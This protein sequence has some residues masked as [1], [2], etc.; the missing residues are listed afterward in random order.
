MV[1]S[2][3]IDLQLQRL[4]KDIQNFK[5]ASEEQIAIITGKGCD[6]IKEAKGRGDTLSSEAV[7]E[8]RKH[9]REMCDRLEHSL[10]LAERQLND[11]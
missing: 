8:L 4:T 9:F 1:T 10:K 5:E 6:I 11:A 7:E 3:F 2:T